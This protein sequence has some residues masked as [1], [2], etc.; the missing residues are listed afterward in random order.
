[1]FDLAVAV[2]RRHETRLERGR[3]QVDAFVQHAVKK[4]LESFDIGSSDLCKTAYRTRVREHEAEHPA[5]LLGA[6]SNAGVAR[7]GSEAV[8]QLSCALAEL[9]V[10]TR[11]VDEFQRREAGRHR[12]RVPG[13]G[14]CLVDRAV[15]RD[16]RHDVGTAAERGGRHAA[17]DDL[18]QRGEIRLDAEQGLCAALGDTKP[19]HDFVEYQNGT[20]VAASISQRL[21]E[22]GGGRNHVHIAGNG[23]DDDAGNI[24]PE[25]VE[26]LFDGIGV[27][28]R[29]RNRMSGEFGGHTG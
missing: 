11:R 3:R 12:D 23:F 10:K 25:L 27:V 24:G 28:V 4:C 29:Q 13:Q 2:S 8:G 26:C 7:R 22:T 17:A 1:M 21:E 18:A 9:F 6:Q 19:G 16:V 5:L 14:S 20:A 15:G